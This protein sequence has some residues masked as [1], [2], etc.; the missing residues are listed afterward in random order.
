MSKTER[1]FIFIGGGT[2][3]IE[4]KGSGAFGFVM[5]DYTTG[6]SFMKRMKT[7]AAAHFHARRYHKLLESLNVLYHPYVYKIEHETRYGVDFEHAR[8]MLPAS[9]ATGMLMLR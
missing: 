2:N 3:Q 7:F 5:H 8:M 9:I 1:H 6:H 4:V